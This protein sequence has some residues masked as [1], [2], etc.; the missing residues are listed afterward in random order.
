LEIGQTPGGCEGLA[1]VTTEITTF[2]YA[3]GALLRRNLQGPGSSYDPGDGQPQRVQCAGFSLCT[4]Q[5]CTRYK[6]G[7]RGKGDIDPGNKNVGLRT[8]LRMSD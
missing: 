5:Y 6:I 8:V 1:A 3:D 2:H 4:D 7:T